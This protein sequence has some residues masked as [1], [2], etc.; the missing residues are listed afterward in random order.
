MLLLALVSSWASGPVGFNLYW[1]LIVLSAVWVAIDSRSI[2]IRRY[3]T[4][5]ALPPVALA[6][7]VGFTWPLA[8]PV[9][10]RT[11]YRIRS[12][13][14]L[15][16]EY[17]SSLKPLVWFV[18]IVGVF[19]VVGYLA[20]SGLRKTLLPVAGEINRDFGLPVNVSSKEGDLTLTIPKS[21]VPDSTRDSLSRQIAACA[22]QKF[23]KPLTTITILYPDVERRGALTITREGPTYSF[24]SD[25]LPASCSGRPQNVRRAPVPVV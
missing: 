22:K 13:Q 3:Q 19:A 25:S 18:S 16:G 17:R 24:P 21:A 11:R 10:L 23:G 2:D 12:H 15:E 1:L 6:A 5:L 8:F 4:Q 7:L 20:T 9:Y 14:I